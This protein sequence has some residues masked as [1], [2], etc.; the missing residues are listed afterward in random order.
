[1]PYA[2]LQGMFESP[3]PYTARLH[4]GGFLDRSRRRSVAVLAD[5]QPANRARGLDPGPAARRRRSPARATAPRSVARRAR[6]GCSAARPG[7]TRRRRLVAAWTASLRALR[8]P[9]RP[10]KPSRTSSA[11]STRA[12]AASYGADVWERLHDIRADWDPDD[13][14]SGGARHP[15]ALSRDR[16]KIPVSWDRHRRAHAAPFPD[17]VVQRPRRPGRELQEG[18]KAMATRER[19]D[20]GHAQPAALGAPVTP[21]P[22][23]QIATG[24]WA[25]KTLAAAHELDLFTRLAGGTETTAQELAREPRHRAAT[26]GDAP[27][28]LRV[29]R[30][31]RTRPRRLPQ[32]RAQRAV[33]RARHPLLLRRPGD[34]VRPAALPGV[35]EAHGGDPH[36]PTDHVGPGARALHV[37]ARGPGGARDLLGGDALAVELHRTHARQTRSISTPRRDCSTSVAAPARSPSSSA[38]ATRRCPRPSSICPT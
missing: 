8:R 34:D 38:G 26:G 31:A 11:T 14:F 27:D 30:P 18:A 2:A 20:P 29:A 37:R 5:L 6:G 15:A 12:S 33:P 24:F 16:R 10:A 25:F 3:E 9:G 35:G 28:R 4:A 13:V 7:S 1:M 21:V 17:R 36:Q 23:M 32:Y 22:L 19:K